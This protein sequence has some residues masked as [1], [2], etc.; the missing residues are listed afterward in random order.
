MQLNPGIGRRGWASVKGSF[1][2]SPSVS[3]ERGIVAPPVQEG[4]S[5]QALA[6]KAGKAYVGPD[7]WLKRAPSH[8]GSWWNEWIRFLAAHSGQPVAPPS[9]GRA[10]QNGEILG[11]APGSYVLQP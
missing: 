6:R 4:H 8:E 2:M 7:E 3:V 5:Y 11:D 1:L 10:G 9:L